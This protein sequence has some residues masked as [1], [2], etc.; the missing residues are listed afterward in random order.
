MKWKTIESMSM[1]PMHIVVE[2]G[3]GTCYDLMIMDDPYG[4]I[5][6]SWS[7]IGGM[8]RYYSK[9]YTGAESEIK[10]LTKS[11]TNNYDHKAIKEIMDA[12]LAKRKLILG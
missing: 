11:W 1:G 8:L 12:Y 2:P 9:E 6:V 7:I 5:I 4:G 10:V 3:N